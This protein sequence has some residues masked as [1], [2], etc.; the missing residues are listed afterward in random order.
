MQVRGEK[1]LA[2][3]ENGMARSSHRRVEQRRH[4]TAVHDGAGRAVEAVLDRR[5]PLDD[6]ESVAL[7]DA[8]VTERRPDVA[9][10]SYRGNLPVPPNP[11]HRSVSRT[12]GFAAGGAGGASTQLLR[13]SATYPAVTA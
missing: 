10:R 4:E 2:V 11:L 5:L 1:R 9:L 6:R 13:G 8:A 12:G 3:V 7:L